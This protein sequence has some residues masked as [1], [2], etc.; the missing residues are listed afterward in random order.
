MKSAQ[1]L[2][3]VALLALGMGCGYSKPATT[4]PAPGTM[5]TVTQLNPSSATSGRASFTLEVDG[6]N[7]A[8]NAFINFNGTKQTTTYVSGTKL[9][10]TI[11]A[12]AIMNSGTVPVTV[13]NPGKPG[14]IY[15]G[16]TSD[17]TSAPVN[18]T[19]N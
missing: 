5:P 19:I 6:T 2:L 9:T 18:F 10:A 12:S 7:F 11:A 8:S 17:A 16:G 1:M 4:P 15:G 3:L 14:G 13:T